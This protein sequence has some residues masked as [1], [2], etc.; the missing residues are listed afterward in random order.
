MSCALR[1][2]R[3]RMEANVV[4]AHPN[5]TIEAA[6]LPLVELGSHVAWQ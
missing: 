1:Q 5:A 6:A 3:D 2:K 4:L